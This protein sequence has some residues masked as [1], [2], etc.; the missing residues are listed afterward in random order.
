MSTDQLPCGADVDDLIGQVADGAAA[1]RSP[2]QQDC[3][4]CQAALAEYDKLFAPVREL[5]AEPVRAPDGTLDEVLRRI[6]ATATDPLY[7]VISTDRGS[8]RIAGRVVAVTA[9]ISTEQI[10][11]VRT[12]LA[13]DEAITTERGS[14]VDAGVA[15][16]STALRITLAAS[17]GEDLPALADRIRATVTHAIRH[18]TGLQPVEI[19]II[20]DDILDGPNRPTDVPSPEAV[21]DVLPD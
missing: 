7:A 12:A 19:T 2:H 6:R 3:L 4:H 1:E 17:Y 11:G 5:A 8:T 9:R 14:D 10:P 16:T 13:R 20:I 21:K 18:T 15:G